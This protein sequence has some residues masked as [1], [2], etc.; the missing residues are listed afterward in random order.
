MI[1]SHRSYDEAVRET[2]LSFEA[3]GSP[4]ITDGEQSKPSFATYPIHGLETLA[5]HGVRFTV[6]NVDVLIA[7]RRRD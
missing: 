7:T 2:I 3:T 4:V 6:A 1:G 5:P